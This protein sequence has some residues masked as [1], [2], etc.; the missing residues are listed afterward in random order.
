MRFLF[1][2]LKS[3]EHN[4][5]TFQQSPPNTPK[6]LPEAPP[7]KPEIAYRRP[8]YSGATDAGHSLVLARDPVFL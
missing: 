2:F 1:V 5:K 3:N 7:E 6:T 8:V 4:I